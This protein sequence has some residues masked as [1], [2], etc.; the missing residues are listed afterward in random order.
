[1]AVDQCYMDGTCDLTNNTLETI[2]LPLSDLFTVSIEGIS[3]DF[4]I[5]I[6]WFLVLMV[7]WIRTHNPAIVAG[8]GLI[9]AGS[10]FPLIPE[11]AQRVGL[12]LVG[13]CIGILLFKLFTSYRNND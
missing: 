9:V 13:L 1:M 6:I 2:M 11:D 7:I 5:L 12:G 10:I 4:T 3:F 8:V